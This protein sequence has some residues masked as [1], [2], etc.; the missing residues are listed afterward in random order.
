ML[1]NKI[2]KVMRKF[3]S[4]SGRKVRKRSQAIAIALSQERKKKK[5]MMHQLKQEMSQ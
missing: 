3:K 4:S 1:K 5:E 2:A